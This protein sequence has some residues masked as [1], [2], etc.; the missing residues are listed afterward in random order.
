MITFVEKRLKRMFWLGVVTDG[1][2]NT[3][4]FIDLSALI[5]ELNTVL[6]FQQGLSGV[7]ELWGEG[8]QKSKVRLSR[9]SL[10]YRILEEHRMRF[11]D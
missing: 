1:T 3:S 4:A 8:G 5:R 11:H 2:C 6:S 9:L 10:P 7:E